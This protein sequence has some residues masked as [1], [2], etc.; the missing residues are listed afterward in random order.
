VNGQPGT[1][2][3]DGGVAIMTITYDVLDGQIVGVRVVSNPA[4]LTGVHL[5][6]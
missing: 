3:T 2:I 6:G 1:V 4:K 5:S